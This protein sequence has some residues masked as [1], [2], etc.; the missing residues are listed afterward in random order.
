MEKLNR[1]AQFVDYNKQPILILGAL[2][3][4]IRSAGGEV[5]GVLFLVIERPKRCFLGLGLQGKLGIHTTQKTAPTEKSK[6][7]VRRATVI[8]ILRTCL[9]VNVNQKIIW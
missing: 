2:K 8:L 7:E 3:A 6:E 9:I 4:D 1:S 5:K